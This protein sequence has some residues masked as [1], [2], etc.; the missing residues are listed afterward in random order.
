MTMQCTVSGTI[1]TGDA[2]CLTGWD[3]GESRP[4]VAAATPAVLATSKTIYG[5]AEGLSGRTI[6]NVLTAGEI[7]PQSITGLVTGAGTSRLVVT[8]LDSDHPGLRHIDDDPPV[9][10]RFVVGTSDENGNLV[11]QPRH[12]SGDTGF[13]KEF[14]V[15]AFGAVPDWSRGRTG[16]IT[17][18]RVVSLPIRGWCRP[19]VEAV[20]LLKSR[21][22]VHAS[23]RENAMYQLVAQ[24][25]C[26]VGRSKSRAVHTSASGQACRGEL[27]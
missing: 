26:T 3:N 11:I 18:R 14:N 5:V 7:A 17:T 21:S 20:R 4:I 13:R 1:N 10:E 8:K 27:K 9:E 19:R 12:F 24:G 2:V 25:V 22:A 16:T 23:P 6:V 15:C